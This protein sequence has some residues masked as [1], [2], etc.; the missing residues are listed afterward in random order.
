ME[1][2]LTDPYEIHP[3]CP[4]TEK[5]P[6]N[7][8]TLEQVNGII[9]KEIEVILSWTSNPWGFTRD[10]FSETLE[11]IKETMETECHN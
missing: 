7:Y 9:D 10:D 3:E 8:L 6:N 4:P 2:P 11:E 1:K 5:K